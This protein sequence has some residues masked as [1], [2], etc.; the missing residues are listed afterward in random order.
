MIERRDCVTDLCEMK[1]TDK[2]FVIDADY[3]RRLLQKR[4]VFRE[5]SGTRNAVHIVLVSA[6]GLAPGAHASVAVATVTT[7]DLFAF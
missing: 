4:A 3:E 7:D 5:E 2:P 1:Y 6:N